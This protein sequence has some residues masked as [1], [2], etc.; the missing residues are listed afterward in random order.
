MAGKQQILDYD[1][2]SIFEEH[3]KKLISEVKKWYIK[4]KFNIETNYN[5]NEAIMSF[6]LKDAYSFHSCEL[7]KFIDKKL[8]GILE[9]DSIDIVN[10]RTMQIKY[11][12]I[13]NY[14]Y[15]A[16]TWTEESW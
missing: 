14:Y 15:T 3:N 2:Q 5:E 6:L 1:R 7:L 8:K 9:E 10:L 13:N 16:P 12:D 11:R 4:D